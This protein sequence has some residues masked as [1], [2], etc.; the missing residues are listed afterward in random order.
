MAEDKPR[1]VV[2]GAGG[3]GKV[4]IDALLAMG[5]CE[6]V[7]VFDDDDAIADRDILGIPVLTSIGRIAELAR[8]YDFSGVAIAIGDNF[9]RDRKFRE[10]RAARLRIPNVI[11]PS[12]HVSRFIRLGE[13]VAILAGATINPGTTIEDN[14]CVNTAASVD[15]DNYLERSC[16][17]YP[18]ATLTGNVRV[19]SFAYVGSG[20]VVTPG[21]SIHRY[22]YVGA[23]A[24]VRKDVPEGVIVAGVPA[25]EIGRQSKRPE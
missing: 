17:V 3:H 7:G 22:S 24:V 15:H 8:K 4:M 1:V 10:I 20:A 19:G 23:G 12:A 5:T 18:N 21:V 14:V 2:W 9:A 25:K 6:V 13:G 11:H 16:H